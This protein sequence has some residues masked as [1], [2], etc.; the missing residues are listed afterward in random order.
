MVPLDQTLSLLYATHEDG[1]AIL[2][3]FALLAYGAIKYCYASG[4]RYVLRVTELCEVFRS[5]AACFICFSPLLLC[6]VLSEL[7]ELC[8][9]CFCSAVLTGRGR[10]SRI[11]CTETL[12]LPS[13]LLSHYF[14]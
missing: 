10:V 5:T 8:L 11:S 3:N 6:F 1:E 13:L 9:G 12:V 2:S 4:I 14:N 7:T